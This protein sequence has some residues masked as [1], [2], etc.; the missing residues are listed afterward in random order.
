MK[1]LPYNSSGSSLVQRVTSISK[2]SLMRIRGSLIFGSL[3]G[4]VIFVTASTYQVLNFSSN[5]ALTGLEKMLVEEK[6]DLMIPEFPSA[7]RARNLSAALRQPVAVRT[8][9]F[10]ASRPPVAARV[11]TLQ[12]ALVVSNPVVDTRVLREQRLFFGSI[13]N[14]A[15]SI[16]RTAKR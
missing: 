8:Q 4:F 12:P 2:I 5:A 16:F 9:N 7:R 14:F 1:A 15:N 11:T 6:K 3:L 13:L 10:G